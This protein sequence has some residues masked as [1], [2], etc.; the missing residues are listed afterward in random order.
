NF[1]NRIAVLLH[2][3]YDGKIPEAGELSEAETKLISETKIQTEKVYKLLENFKFRDAQFGAMNIARAG[4][5]YL[6]DNE[7]WKLIKTD[8]I[9]TATIMYTAAQTVGTLAAIF[10][11]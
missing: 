1:I 4:N 2:K 8:A 10:Q 5:K 11:P 7:P 6:A 3:F 9:R